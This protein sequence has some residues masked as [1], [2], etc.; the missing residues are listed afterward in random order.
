MRGPE[1]AGPELGLST[2]AVTVASLAP[3]EN[4]TTSAPPQPYLDP[5]AVFRF[6]HNVDFT[7]RLICVTLAKPQLLPGWMP[8][9]PLGRQAGGEPLK[10]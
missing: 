1:E 3:N 7:V 10:P 6:P 8:P 5:A 4:R 2:F 9:S